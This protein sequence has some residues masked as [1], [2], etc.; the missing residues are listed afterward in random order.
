M[1][2]KPKYK[3]LIIEGTKYKTQYN[4]KFENRIEWEEPDVRKVMSFI[5]GT[6][7][8]INVKEGQ[9]VKKGQILFILEAMKMKNK[10]VSPITGKVK[11]INVKNGEKIPNKHLILEFE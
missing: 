6:I 5:P 1:E 8:K 11:S 4:R 9:S 3:T 10:V 7:V 2:K